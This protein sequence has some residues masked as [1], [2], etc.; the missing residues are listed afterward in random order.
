LTPRLVRDSGYFDGREEVF[1]EMTA[2]GIVPSESILMYDHKMVK[3]R[4][5]L[6]PKKSRR[7]KFVDYVAALFGIAAAG[8]EGWRA[9]I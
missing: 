7:V 1:S 4:A 2:L 3:E 8:S 5:L 9:R 6:L